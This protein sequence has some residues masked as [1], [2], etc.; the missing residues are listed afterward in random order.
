MKSIIQIFKVLFFLFIF[1]GCIDD[2]LL[3]EKRELPVDLAYDGVFILNE[4]NF[5]YENASISYY[6]KDDG[7]VFDSIF[8]N[9]NALPLGDV[10]HSMILWDSLAYVVLNNS[11]RIYVFNAFDFEFAGSITGLT[12]PRYIHFVSDTKGYITD[13]YGREI[14]IFDPR[15]LEVT[16]TIDVIG[17]NNQFFQHSTEQMVQSGHMLFV[18]SWSFNDQVLII[19]TR[20]DE[21]VDSIRVGLQPQSMVKD[22]TGRIWVL[23]DGG[24][25]GNPFGHEK[26]SLLTI[27]PQT[28]QVD[29]KFE[30]DL[31]ES[32]RELKINS[33]GDTL[34]F[35]NKDVYRWAVHSDDQPRLFFESKYELVNSGYFGLGIDPET[36]EIYVGDGIDFLQPGLVYRLAPD[37]TPLDTIQAGILPKMFCFRPIPQ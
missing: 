17:D 14:S 24:Y 7:K 25:T 1:T 23:C 12:S 30:F 11:G 13:L 3:W 34:Y 36:S 8:F 20:N 10:G 2:D 31:N 18:N 5:F 27:D 33:T 16:G 28:L 22:N 15:T 35:I 26:P 6:N 9:T 32:P 29:K 19:D 21:L 37:G 4:G